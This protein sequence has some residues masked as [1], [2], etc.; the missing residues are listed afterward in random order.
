VARPP[1]TPRGRASW[2]TTTTR[3]R[4][5]S[6]MGRPAANLRSVKILQARLALALQPAARRIELPGHL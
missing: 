2:V 4:R 5:P 3:I 1:W 6:S